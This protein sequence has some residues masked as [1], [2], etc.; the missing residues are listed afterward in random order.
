MAVETLKP[1]RV[2]LGA[3]HVARGHD[4]IVARASAGAVLG[5]GRVNVGIPLAAVPVLKEEQ[6]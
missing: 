6:T 4:V 5:N 1:D 3:A 2:S